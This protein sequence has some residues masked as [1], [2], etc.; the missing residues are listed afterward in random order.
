MEDIAPKSS[1]LDLSMQLFHYQKVVHDLT[2]QVFNQ[3][4]L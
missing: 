2:R 4:A 3:V 1:S